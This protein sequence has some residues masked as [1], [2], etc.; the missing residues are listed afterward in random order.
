MLAL[1]FSAP[2]R[3]PVDSLKFASPIPTVGPVESQPAVTFNAPESVFGIVKFHVT[4]EP[5]DV[6]VTGKLPA[7]PLNKFLTAVAI[8]VCAVAVSP[9][10]LVQFCC[11][12]A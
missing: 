12:R 2:A 1:P 9:A 4:V 10:A 5:L 11:S 3:V 8:A 7:I 6:T